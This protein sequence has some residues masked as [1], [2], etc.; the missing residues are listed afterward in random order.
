MLAAAAVLGAFARMDASARAALI[1]TVS[2][3]MNATLRAYAE[4][5][6][7][8]AAHIAEGGVSEREE[9]GGEKSI[10]IK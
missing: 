2:R 8:T 10:R 7:P 3:K 6:F 9:K 4:G 1:E 5:A